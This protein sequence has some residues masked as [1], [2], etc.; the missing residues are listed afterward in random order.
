MEFGSKPSS[1]TSDQRVIDKLFAMEAAVLLSSVLR[2]CSA[3][4]GKNL[5]MIELLVK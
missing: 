4:I 3:G 1:Q 5:A 2:V